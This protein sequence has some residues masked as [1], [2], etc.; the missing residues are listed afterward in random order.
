MPLEQCLGQRVNARNRLEASF[1]RASAASPKVPAN[2]APAQ[3]TARQT[4]D[5]RRP[6]PIRSTVISA[7]RPPAHCASHL[8]SSPLPRMPEAQATVK[9]TPT[10]TVE[11][12]GHVGERQVSRDVHNYETRRPQPR[13]PMQSSLRLGPRLPPR[14]SRPAR[15]DNTEYH[16]DRAREER[17][18]VR[19]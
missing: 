7:W 4:V 16:A 12:G 14:R 11:R 10:Q 19:A 15:H 6:M 1:Q 13:S 18:P 5:G 17:L 2:V 3:S 9:R 8:R